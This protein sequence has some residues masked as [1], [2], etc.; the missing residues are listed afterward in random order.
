MLFQKKN[1]NNNMLKHMFETATPFK[2]VRLLE[3]NQKK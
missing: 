3:I 2:Y 1:N